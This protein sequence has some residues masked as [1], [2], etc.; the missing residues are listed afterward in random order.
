MNRVILGLAVSFGGLIASIPAAHADDN[1]SDINVSLP[2]SLPRGKGYVVVPPPPEGVFIAQPFSNILFL[3]RCTGGCTI[4]AG[5]QDNSSNNVSTVADGTSALSAFRWSETVWQ[6]TLAC[7]QDIFSP[8][9]I[10]VTDADPGVTP[11]ME[12]IV[13]GTA[14]QLDCSQCVPG[15][16]GIAPVA[17]DCEYMPRSMSYTFANENYYGAG[18]QTRNVNELCA[19]IGQEV[20]HTWGMDHEIL[21]SDPMTYASYN[22]RRQ[23]EDAAIQ[24]GEYPGQTHSCFCGGNTQNSVQEILQRFGPGGPPTPPHMTITD[25]AAGAQV[26]Q[27]FAVVAEGDEPLGRVELRIDGELIDTDTT[28]PYEFF[29]P[30]DL[31]D[32]THMVEVTG[33]DNRGDPG[34]KTISVIIGEP[35]QDDGDCEEI[36]EGLVCLGGRCVLGNGYEGGLG[37]PCEGDDDCSSGTCLMQG[38]DMYCVESCNPGSDEC[39]GDFDCLDFEDGGVCWPAD[40][41]GG[42]GCA[43][44]DA[45]GAAALPIGFGLAFVGMLFRRRRR[46]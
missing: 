32:G 41:G 33:Y 20:A 22:G 2:T 25:P 3:N 28:G 40:G 37:T 1:D 17:W 42:G 34:K 18:S 35:C 9:N 31:A 15:V 45:G 29:A 12:A 13:A 38:D 26:Q 16:L 6:E 7:V 14:T 10:V 24:C 46:A 23:F 43:S 5:G 27:G 44:T 21:A 30:S 8:F 19:T 4:Q 39:P 11:H 36:G